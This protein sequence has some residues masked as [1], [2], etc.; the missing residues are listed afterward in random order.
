MIVAGA[1]RMTVSVEDAQFLRS[2]HQSCTCHRAF[3]RVG[4][5]RV[6]TFRGQS[7]FQR[8]PAPDLIRGGSRFASRKR[9]KT[10]ILAA[11]GRSPPSQ[12]TNVGTAVCETSS[13]V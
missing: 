5:Y 8:K 10:R 7:V 12:N 2:A 11:T 13:D 6:S 1:Y 9:V 3:K 4:I